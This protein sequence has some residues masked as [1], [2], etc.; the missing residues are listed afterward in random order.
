MAD[1]A[2]LRGARIFQPSTSRSEIA[3][4]E[5]PEIRARDLDPML[6]ESEGFRTMGT[7]HRGAE[8]EDVLPFVAQ[9][10]R[11]LVLRLHAVVSRAVRH[12]H[13]LQP[14]QPRARGAAL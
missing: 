9:E 1:M 14:D 8:V 12:A 5:N 3:A 6:S 10:H 11:S 7:Q 13:L 2:R 4:L